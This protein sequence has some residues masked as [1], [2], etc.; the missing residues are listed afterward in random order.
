MKLWQNNVDLYACPCL[1]VLAWL[2]P[3]PY[4]KEGLLSYKSSDCYQN[5]VWGWVRSTC[6]GCWYQENCYWKDY[7]GYWFQLTV[8]GSHTQHLGIL[9]CTGKSLSEIE[10]KTT[11]SM[12][13]SSSLLGLLEFGG[14]FGLKLPILIT[15]VHP[16]LNSH[17]M[18]LGSHKIME[19]FFFWLSEMF[20]APHKPLW[21]S[22][23]LGRRVFLILM[24]TVSSL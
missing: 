14:I 8:V 9:L 15:I 2:S 11:H 16:A 19:C 13:H 5:F 23:D 7:W 20:S 1:H 6:E 24:F 21:T 4:S 12:D 17:I 18:S 10:W 3:S 22:H